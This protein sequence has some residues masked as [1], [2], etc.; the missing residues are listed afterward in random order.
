VTRLQLRRE[1]IDESGP[2]W[3][4]GGEGRLVGQPDDRWPVSN[5]NKRSVGLP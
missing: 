5:E 1:Q 2:V 4:G 3:A